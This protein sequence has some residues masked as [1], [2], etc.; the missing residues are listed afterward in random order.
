MGWR[1]LRSEGDRGSRRPRAERASRAD[2][3]QYQ[4][5]YPTAADLAERETSAAGNLTAFWQRQGAYEHEVL[6]NGHYSGR[7]RPA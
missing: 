2:G 5:P 4:E 7:T 3:M 1:R 6:M